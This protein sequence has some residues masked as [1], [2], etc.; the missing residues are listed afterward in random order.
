MLEM[1]DIEVMQ[2]QHEPIVDRA[3]DKILS[4]SYEAVSDESAIDSLTGLMNRRTF[5]QEIRKR[6]TNVHEQQY[7]LVLLDLDK[8]QAVNDLCGFEGGD[9]LLR[10]L[11]SILISYLPD[12]GVV[13]R[14]GDDEFVLLIEGQNLEQGYQT[15]ETLRQ[16]I[17][18]Y[19]YEWEDRLI[20]V[21][22]SIGLVHVETDEHS[23]SELLQAALAA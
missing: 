15:A 22:A 2:S 3:I 11:S 23:P 6:L 16:A 8:F 9:N 5:D 20:P 7:V 19:Q 18:E 14:I 1:H 10:S 12:Q 17:E 13:A 4:R 21:S